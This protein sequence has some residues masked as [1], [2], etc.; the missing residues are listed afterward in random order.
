MVSLFISALILGSFGPGDATAVYKEKCREIAASAKIPLIQLEYK[1]G[2]KT[3][4][5]ESAQFEYAKESPD[6]SIVFQAASVSKP[7]FAYIV[8]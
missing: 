4:S 8:L 7:V 1:S 6:C 5:F 3:I 2:K